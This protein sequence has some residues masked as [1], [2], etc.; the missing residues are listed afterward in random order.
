MPRHLP[1]YKAYLN[2]HAAHWAGFGLAALL[3]ASAQADDAG[4]LRCSQTADTTQRLACYDA[5]AAQVKQRPA[6]TAM[7]APAPAA[8]PTETFGMKVDTPKA[9]TVD[10]I[11]TRL[12]GR[13]NG[14][15]AGQTFSLANGQVWQVVDGTVGFGEADNPAVTIRRGVLGAYFMEVEGV[16]RSPRVKRVQ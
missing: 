1:R 10:A 8:A 9:E 7:A 2:R 15:K 5:L 13:F 11:D 16:R 6:T 14:W 12:N 4:L 3:A